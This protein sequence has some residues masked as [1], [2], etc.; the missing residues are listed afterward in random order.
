MLTET[1]H[2]AF[3]EGNGAAVDL[4]LIKTFLLSYVNRDILMLTCVISIRKE[5]RS[6]SKKVDHSLTFT[7]LKARLLSS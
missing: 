7:P 6:L 3:I 5:R 4:L 1:A 2:F